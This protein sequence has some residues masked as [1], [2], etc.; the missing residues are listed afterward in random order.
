MEQQQQSHACTACQTM[1][2][3]SEKQRKHY[4]TD[5]HRYNLKRKVA[6]MPPLPLEAFLAKMSTHEKQMKVLSGEIKTP[7]GYCAACRKHFNTEGAFENHL[8]SKKHREIAAAFDMRTDKDVVENNR[9]NRKTSESIEENDDVVD[10]D[11]KD[12]EVEE[13]DSDEWDEEGDG[14]AVPANDCIF[15]SHHSKDLENNVTHLTERHCFFL[16]DA[17]YLADLEG[18]LTY[19][20]EKVG[21]GLMCLYCNERSKNFP[22]LASVQ[23]HMADKQ[24]CRLKTDQGSL[25][26]YSRFYDYSA[27]YPDGEQPGDEDEG[28][29]EIELDSLDDTGY[30]LVLP[31]GARVGHRSLLRYYRQSLNPDRKVQK[32]GVNAHMLQRY[33]ALGYTGG[34]TVAQAKQKFN[35]VKFMKHKFMKQHMQVGVKSNKLQKGTFQTVPR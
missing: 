20:G 25:I 21:K 17:E 35:D 24:H 19:M 30:E 23:R 12:M 10:D 6:E 3:D 34:L 26:E 8:K 27:S 32:T 4:K 13:V 15:C 29:E 11:D 5:W 28:E 16:P 7:D 14:E 33:K 9:M 22:N 31:S 18:M 2:D 1:F